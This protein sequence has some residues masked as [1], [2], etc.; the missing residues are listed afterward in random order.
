MNPPTAIRAPTRGFTLI[1]MIVVVAIL[2]ILA[3]AAVPLVELSVK[4]AQERQLRE[5]LRQIRTAIDAHRTAVEGRRIVAGPGPGG[6][7][8]PA[9]LDV[10]ADGAPML[11][12]EGQPRAD[13]A[14]L[15]FL[16][17]LPRDPFADRDLP[18]AETWGL[19]S[20]TSPADSPSPG[21]DVFDVHSRSDVPA[22]DGSRY[23]DW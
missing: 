3:T 22:I 12:A 15:H 10:L 6:G 7:I 18:A 17:R 5:A 4:R 2:G 11:D 1:E 23:R 21:A 13:G 20:S 8:Y 14:R 16:R 9:S 19:R